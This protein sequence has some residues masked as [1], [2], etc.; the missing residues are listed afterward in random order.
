MKLAYLLLAFLLVLTSCANQ[1]VSTQMFYA[2]KQC[3]EQRA[4]VK[5]FNNKEDLNK[6]SGLANAF[7]AS[8]QKLDLFSNFDFEKYLAVVVAAGRQRNNGYDIV[9]T[10]SQSK[11]KGK[12]VVLP[13]EFVTPAP[14]IRYNQIATTPCMIIGVEKAG[15]SKI[16]AGKLELNLK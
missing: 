5:L 16:K 10:N 6:V 13:V 1:T 4:S 9:L 15:Y 8:D 3:S 14:G 2:S 11:L 12:T 7:G